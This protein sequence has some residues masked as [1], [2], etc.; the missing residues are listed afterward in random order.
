MATD[1]SA[2]GRNISSPTSVN[3]GGSVIVGGALTVP[4]T[5]DV[6]GAFT[7]PGTVDIAGTLTVPGTADIAGALTVPGT[8][9]VAG[10]LTIPGTVDVAGALTVPGSVDVTGTYTLPDVENVDYQESFIGGAWGAGPPAP[11]TMSCTRRGNIVSLRCDEAS[12]VG[13]SA[14]NLTITST[15]GIPVA[16]RPT[17]PLIVPLLV[18]DNNLYQGTGQMNISAVGNIEIYSEGMAVFTVTAGLCGFQS[19]NVTYGT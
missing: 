11:V 1:F 9:D 3:L 13:D 16:Y 7:A 14:G 2:Q 12:A 5:I 6:A 8:A 15:I 10:A 18:I 17:D 4:G 19:F